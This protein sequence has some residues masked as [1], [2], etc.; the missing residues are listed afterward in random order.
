MLEVQLIKFIF[1]KKGIF[2]EAIFQSKYFSLNLEQKLRNFPNSFSNLVVFSPTYSGALI[3]E[4]GSLVNHT[5]L[6]F[7]NQFLDFPK[8]M[9]FQKIRFLRH[10]GLCRKYLP[11]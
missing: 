9:K 3:S 11:V 2:N 10:Y 1:R 7:L 5:I 8:K 6:R 4:T